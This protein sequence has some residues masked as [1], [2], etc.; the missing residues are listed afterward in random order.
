VLGFNLHETSMTTD[1]K[2]PKSERPPGAL[3]Q[4]RDAFIRTFV[5]KGV[6]ITEDLVNENAKLRKRVSDLEAKNAT[7]MAQL[8]SDDAIREL[9]KKIEMLERE[10][11]GLL[12]RFEEVE[13]ESSRW[14][15]QYSELE[16]ELSNLANLYIAGNHLHGSRDFPTLILRVK[17]L[18]SQ[19][20]GARTFAMYLATSDGRS[21]V[22]VMSEGIGKPGPIPVVA[23]DG[24]IGETFATAMTRI[25][26]GKLD[27]GSI[28]K[29][30]AL[31]PMKV[32]D[33]VVG[34]LAI[35]AALEH[36]SHFLPVDFELLTLLGAHAGGALLC[37]RIA[38][39]LGDKIPS[40]DG[41]ISEN[42]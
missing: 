15:D 12:S 5:K 23:D 16:Q 39:D 32:E 10:K 36:K 34:V 20:V 18:L 19:F 40:F 29:P 8:A 21:L 31:V 3:K 42:S 35:F 4:E 6:Q 33:K 14:G 41:F 9:L 27:D 30:L 26:R 28:E 2:R 13:A 22:P 7:L 11:R 38:A 1:K 24:G 25:E 17:E 37:A